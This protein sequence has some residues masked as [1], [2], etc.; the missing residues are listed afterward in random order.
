MDSTWLLAGAVSAAVTGATGSVHCALM[1]G[2]LAC[3]SMGPH[4]SPA[5]IAGWQ[6]GRLS[7]YVV[8]GAALGS[9]GRGVSHLFVASVAQYLPW[10]MALGLIIA[11]FDLTKRIPFMRRGASTVLSVA[12]KT[13]SPFS[14]SFL[15]GVATPLLPCGLLYGL[16][17]AATAAGGA[18]E[19][20]VLL[21]SF[22][23][24][25]VPALLAAQLG[26]AR[27]NVN[28]WIR[29]VV[30]LAAAAVLI[31]RALLARNDVGH[32]G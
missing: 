14:R 25:A 30:P 19:G 11:A 27:L 6:L 9:I 4:R 32:C 18:L 8:I 5:A 1:C 7:A 20:A 10:V 2:P 17:L 31:V 16:F 22:A 12:S 15:F 26:L 29:R 3:A 28:P 13:E 21:A 23:L 24:G